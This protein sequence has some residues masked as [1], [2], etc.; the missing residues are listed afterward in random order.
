VDLGPDQSPTTILVTGNAVI[1]VTGAVAEEA[2]TLE[3]A[4]DAAAPDQ[5]WRLSGERYTI[6]LADDS[7][8]TDKAGVLTML[9]GDTS[10]GTLTWQGA[11]NLD[12]SENSAT[13]TR[14]VTARTSAGSASGQKITMQFG[15]D[16]ET[17]HRTVQQI[18]LDGKVRFEG[19]G[20]DALDL[21]AK[22]ALAIFD[23][24]G[25]LSQFI[26]HDEVTLSAQNRRL[27]A[28]Q[29]VLKFDHV[30]DE[31]GNKSLEVVNATAEKDVRIKYD[32]REIEAGADRVDWNRA[33]DSYTL[34][35]DP[36]WIM[37][38]GLRSQGKTLTYY[39]PTG[40]TQ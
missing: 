20:E 25:K 31:E 18:G 4:A 22:S 13:F 37:R 34:T 38:A 17:G 27:T 1:E 28:G 26:A 11:M 35:G 2:A 15:I 24:D 40:A 33:V 9:T 6:D 10:A 5:R 3:T 39:G 16:K 29:L 32:N 12:M 21:T 19:T 30:E 8:S 23:E 7:V 14:N 36:A